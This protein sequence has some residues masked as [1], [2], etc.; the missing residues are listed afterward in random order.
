GMYPAEP[1]DRNWTYGFVRR[2][3][4]GAS[5]YSLFGVQLISDNSSLGANRFCSVM[6]PLSI[7]SVAAAI[8][9]VTLAV[10][11]VRQRRRRRVGLCPACGYDLRATPERCPEC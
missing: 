9:P 5:V 1:R 2:E 11:R 7:T 3:G 8:L 4:K 10:R 6:V